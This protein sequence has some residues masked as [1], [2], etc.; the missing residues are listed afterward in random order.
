MSDQNVVSVD[1][2]VN[3]DFDRLGSELEA[4][5]LMTAGFVGSI[6]RAAGAIVSRSRYSIEHN[7]ARLPTF[8]PTATP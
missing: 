3:P 7:M 5:E 2:D 6:T 1:S 4:F 8:R